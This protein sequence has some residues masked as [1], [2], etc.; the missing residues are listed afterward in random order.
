M[1][2]RLCGHKGLGAT[3]FTLRATRCVSSAESAKDCA[4][5]LLAFG[6]P[7]FGQ[8]ILELRRRRGLSMVTAAASAKVSAAY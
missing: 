6:V 7:S 2:E 5:A 1:Q 4:A 3:R 8:V